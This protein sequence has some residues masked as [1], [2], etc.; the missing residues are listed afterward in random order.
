MRILARIYTLPYKFVC[1]AGY[2]CTLRSAKL[3]CGQR[4]VSRARIG[5]ARETNKADK[6]LSG[7][8]CMFIREDGKPMIN[9]TKY[10]TGQQTLFGET[11]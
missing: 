4:V 6:G 11:L 10:T 9:G 3:T 8:S 1:T 2:Y 5:L 7:C